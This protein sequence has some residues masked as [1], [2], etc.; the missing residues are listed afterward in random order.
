MV[1]STA[2]FV[3]NDAVMKTFAGEMDWYQA[4]ALRGVFTVAVSAAMC[5]AI[6]GRRPLRTVLGYARDR[7]T[8]L[9]VLGE[10]G[11]TGFFLLA[12]FEIALAN[13]AA[14]TQVLPLLSE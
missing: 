14:I 1:A 7:A 2:C 3:A 5:L 9:R 4:L 12:L 10:I 8:V 13:V 11:S 6:D